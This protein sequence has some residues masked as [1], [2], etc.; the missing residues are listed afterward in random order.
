MKSRWLIEAEDSARA[1]TLVRWTLCQIKLWKNRQPPFGDH[2]AL[3]RHIVQLCNAAR[4]ATSEDWLHLIEAQIQ[5]C[6]QQ[7]NVQK[8]KWEKLVPGFENPHISKAVI[9]KPWVSDQEKGVVLVNFEGQYMRL[10]RLANLKEFAA[11]YTLVVGP[12]WHLPHQ[13]VNC[14]FPEVYPNKVFSLISN[15]RD[16]EVL[17]RLSPKFIPLPLYGSSW[18]NPLLFKPLPWNERNVDILM[19]ANWSK[20]KRHHALF[21]ALRKMPA[22]KCLT[23]WSRSRWAH[24]TNDSFR[25]TGLWSSRPV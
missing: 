25:S 2:Q 15:E 5:Q 20:T 8:V 1:N 21:K 22:N 10:L 6:V 19:V 18:V 4:L 13:L 24:S 12:S 23:D 3:A 7:L 14:V 11:R 9:L 17:P 16:L